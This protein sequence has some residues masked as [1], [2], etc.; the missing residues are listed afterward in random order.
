MPGGNFFREH[1]GHRKGVVQSYRIFV[2]GRDRVNHAVAYAPGFLRKG[3]LELKA[4]V[5]PDIRVVGLQQY[6][7]WRTR[8]LVAL[9]VDAAPFRIRHYQVRIHFALVPKGGARLIQ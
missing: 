1:H 4:H 9:H 3:S 2:E 6:R 7:V 5:K 8:G